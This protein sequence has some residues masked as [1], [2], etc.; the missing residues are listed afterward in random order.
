M[1][2]SIELR[3]RIGGG[4]SYGSGTVVACSHGESGGEYKDGVKHLKPDK[5]SL[6]N[7]IQ[8]SKMK[9]KYI[10]PEIT[11]MKVHTE[12]VMVVGSIA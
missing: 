1:A 9:K 7:K 6:Q 11:L 12:N 8:A 4:H 5:I 10:S 2:L 3:G